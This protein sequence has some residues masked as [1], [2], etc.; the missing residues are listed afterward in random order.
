MGF[1][2]RVV[3][4]LVIQ[5]APL[6]SLSFLLHPLV[7]GRLTCI[8]NINGSLVFGFWFGPADRGHQQKN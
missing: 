2:G 6:N 3:S 5:F 7:H 4:S 8:D 1:G